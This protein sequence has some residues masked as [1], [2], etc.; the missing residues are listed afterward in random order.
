[1]RSCEVQQPRRAGG[2]RHVRGD[3]RRLQPRHFQHRLLI[4]LPALRRLHRLVEVDAAAGAHQLLEMLDERPLLVGELHVAHQLHW[5][6]LDHRLASERGEGETI[7]LL[8]QVLADHQGTKK[9]FE[10]FGVQLECGGD[11][12][13]RARA[14]AQ[15]FEDAET[16]ARHDR[17]RFDEAEER[18]E[19]RNGNFAAPERHAFEEVRGDE[20]VLH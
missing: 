20:A 11:V 16:S 13:G 6:A 12:S 17:E 9:K 14:V 5:R 7:A 3:H 8:H 2:H 10:R 1:M 15:R 4:V 18:I 19:E